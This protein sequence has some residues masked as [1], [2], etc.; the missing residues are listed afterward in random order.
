MNSFILC[1]HR[2]DDHDQLSCFLA[3]V[4]MIKVLEVL[5][6]AVMSTSIAVILHQPIVWANQLNFRSVSESPFA[7]SID[8]SM[9]SIL[10]FNQLPVVASK[11]R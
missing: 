6:D 2:P 10:Q 8:K 5:N 7:Y 1:R 4:L 9:N 3:G 11:Y